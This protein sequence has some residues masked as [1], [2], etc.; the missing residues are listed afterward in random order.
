[1]M[2]QEQRIAHAEAAGWTNVR[3]SVVKRGSKKRL[4]VGNSPDGKGGIVPNFMKSNK[5]MIQC[6][7]CLQVRI[8]PAAHSCHGEKK[9]HRPS[10]SPNCSDD[11]VPETAK[12]HN[13]SC[14]KS[15]LDRYW[16]LM[17]VCERL[18]RERNAAI[19]DAADCRQIIH[20]YVEEIEALRALHS[21]ENVKV[22]R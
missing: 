10:D 14:G 3:E 4:L 9:Y 22:H 7:I 13:E 1:M 8:D 19:K 16:I 6:P 18:E 20:T 5:P 15:T 11:L 12:C 21:P 17:R 2:E